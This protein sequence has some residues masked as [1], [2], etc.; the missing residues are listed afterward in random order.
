MHS[1]RRRSA[2]G[3]RASSASITSTRPTSWIVKS[4]GSV[5]SAASAPSI[6]ACGAWSPPI[7][8]S[9]TR[10]TVSCPLP[11]SAS[12]RRSSRRTRRR[13]AADAASYSADRP[14][15]RMPAPVWWPRRSRLRD[16][17]VLRFGT[18]MT[19]SS[20][21]RS[22]ALRT[23]PCSGQPRSGG[24]ARRSRRGTADRTAP[25]APAPHA[26]TRQGRCAWPPARARA[27]RDRPGASGSL[28]E[29]EPDIRYR[30]TEPHRRGSDGTAPAPARE[31][32]PSRSNRLAALA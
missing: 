4:P 1:R 23:V 17:E 31:R 24:R 19:S 28:R 30:P 16:F 22:R 21:V 12:C 8:S 32:G 18:A 27:P 14:G 11:R 29:H 5:S 20:V 7:A 9:A 3:W 15:S 13:G 10:I 25:P 26:R 6:S 2:P